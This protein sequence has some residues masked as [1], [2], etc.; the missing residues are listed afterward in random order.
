MKFL[1]KLGKKR[2][3]NMTSGHFLQYTGAIKSNMYHRA[4]TTRKATETEKATK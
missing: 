2:H 1:N 3:L 4:R